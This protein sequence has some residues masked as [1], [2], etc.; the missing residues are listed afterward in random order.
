MGKKKKRH[1]I[2]HKE[3]LMFTR[4]IQTWLNK[5]TDLVQQFTESK[6]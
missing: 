1:E 6:N 2:K 5:L 4:N 3:M